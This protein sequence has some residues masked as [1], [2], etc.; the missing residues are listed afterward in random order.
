MEQI[1]Q[2]TQDEYFKYRLKDESGY[3]DVYLQNNKVFLNFFEGNSARY[4]YYEIGSDKIKINNLEQY[5]GHCNTLM[6]F[7]Q[8]LAKKTESGEIKLKGEKSITQIKELYDYYYNKHKKDDEEQEQNIENNI[9]TQEPQNKNTLYENVNEKEK[10]ILNTIFEVDEKK[11]ESD[12]DIKRI[13]AEIKIKDDKVVI[14][15]YEPSEERLWICEKEANNS[16]CRKYVD[17]TDE[18]DVGNDIVLENN[19]NENKYINKNECYRHSFVDKKKVKEVELD[20]KLLQEGKVMQLSIGKVLTFNLVNRETFKDEYEYKI[21][22]HNDM[23]N[24]YEYLLNNNDT[25]DIGS[26]K[27]IKILNFLFSSCKDQVEKKDDG[28][29]DKVHNG[30]PKGEVLALYDALVKAIAKCFSFKPKIIETDTNK[31]LSIEL[32]YNKGQFLI[33]INPAKKEMTYNEQTY[34]YTDDES[35]RQFIKEN[36]Y[37]EC[38]ND[39]FEEYMKTIWNEKIEK[40]VN[41]LD[42][43]QILMRESKNTDLIESLSQNPC[44]R[45]LCCIYD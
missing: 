9:N 12:K 8:T 20:I 1:Q 2:N 5:F 45:A 7:L 39:N 24:N 3:F 29:E 37:R 14:S 40:F 35:M 13:H 15:F 27:E 22:E 30:I 43:S 6:E 18:A 34:K 32:P 25:L 16:S 36:L 42:L 19:N 44:V 33:T 31:Y 21:T 11:E 26:D 17:P 38:L 10:Y 23:I 28:V 4:I 41:E